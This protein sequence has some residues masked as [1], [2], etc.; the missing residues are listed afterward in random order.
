MSH[1][2]VAISYLCFYDRYNSFFIFYVD[3]LELKSPFFGLLV[4]I[5]NVTKRMVV[6]TGIMI[7]VVI[8]L[9]IVIFNDSFNLD[10]LIIFNSWWFRFNLCYNSSFMFV[11][12]HRL[13]Y[14]WTFRYGLF[15]SIY[16]WVISSISSEILKLFAFRFSQ[17]NASSK[18]WKH[19]IMICSNANHHRKEDINCPL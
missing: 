7:V 10:I 15:W 5:E 11:I 3:M 12:H 18:K 14:R 1:R 13:S 6:P 16:I 17:P 2:L 8:S 9:T 4:P 19:A